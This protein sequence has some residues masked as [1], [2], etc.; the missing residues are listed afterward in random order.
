MGTVDRRALGGDLL[1]R[2]QVGAPVHE[3]RDLGW[4]PRATALLDVPRQQL[5]GHTCLGA[6][7]PGIA[8]VPRSA[9]RRNESGTSNR[10][11]RARSGVK[12]SDSAASS[13]KPYGPQ[14]HGL[15]DAPTQSM[16]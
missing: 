9:Q 6:S 11:K 8:T 3:G 16:I 5:H 12:G 7:A 10:P 14:N 2:D 13:T 4:D 15:A 1:E